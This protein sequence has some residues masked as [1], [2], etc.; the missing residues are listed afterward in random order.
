MA[1][2]LSRLNQWE[3][4]G[5][6]PC[7]AQ[8]RLTVGVSENPLSSRKTRWAPSRSAFFYMRP[9]GPSPVGDGPLVALEGSA[10]WLLAAPPQP[11]QETPDG[12][13][14]IGHGQPPAHHL[15]NP[16]GGPQVG[17]VACGQRTLQEQVHEAALLGRGEFGRA[18][19]NRFWG[20][21]PGTSPL[22]GVHPPGD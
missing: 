14:M 10:L 3:S 12:V 22:I 11:S 17:A 19:W 5:V 4:C 8:V 21:A 7:G 13:G 15:G 2:S 6:C 20:E 16:R 1:E 9:D 18:S